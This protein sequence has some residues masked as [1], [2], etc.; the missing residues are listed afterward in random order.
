ML[1]TDTSQITGL[2]FTVDE[3]PADSRMRTLHLRQVDPDGTGL[4]SYPGGQLWMR[5]LH[6]ARY[7]NG[8]TLLRLNN[9]AT[10]THNR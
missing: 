6:A 4:F 10:L 9:G 3:E 8:V 7:H 5:I 1:I 2:D